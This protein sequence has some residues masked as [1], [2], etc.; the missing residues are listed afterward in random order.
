[1]PDFKTIK[2]KDLYTQNLTHKFSGNTPAYI[3]SGGYPFGRTLQPKNI[4]VAKIDSNEN[5]IYEF[6]TVKANS[7]H[8]FE[9]DS[10]KKNL[11]III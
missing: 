11:F 10:L 5:I 1:M 6:R 4:Y 7:Y 9:Y 2:I 3:F 8:S